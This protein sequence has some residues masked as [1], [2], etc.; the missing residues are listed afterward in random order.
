[1]LVLELCIEAVRKLTDLCFNS[2]IP[3][4]EYSFQAVRCSFYNPSN[5]EAF[6]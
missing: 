5:A 3:R 4:H 2:C 1:M 6:Y